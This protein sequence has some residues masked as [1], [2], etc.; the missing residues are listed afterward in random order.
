MLVVLVLLLLHVV[1]VVLGLASF[2]KG[3]RGLVRSHGTAGA[4]CAAQRLAGDRQGDG[5]IIAGV[6]EAYKSMRVAAPPLDEAEAVPP[7]LRV[8][9]RGDACKDD[10]RVNMRGCTRECTP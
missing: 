8:G 7:D 1:L 3:R 9:A 5:H 10:R 6:E 2:G 4:C